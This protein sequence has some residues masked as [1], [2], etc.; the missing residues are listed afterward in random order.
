MG[1]ITFYIIFA[2]ITQFLTYKWIRKVD[3]KEREKLQTWETDYVIKTNEMIQQFKEQNK[4]SSEDIAVT[5][6]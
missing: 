6:V 4:K 2:V 3:H 1:Y 5:E